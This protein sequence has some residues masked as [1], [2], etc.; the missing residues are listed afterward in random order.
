[1]LELAGRTDILVSAGCRWPMRRPLATAEQVHGRT[2]LDGPELAEPTMPLPNQAPEG[3]A[4]RGELVVA[5]ALSGA[6]GCR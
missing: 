4:Q 1:M 3:S 6:F 2:G 5:V